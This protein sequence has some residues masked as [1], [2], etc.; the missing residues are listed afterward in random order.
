MW[1]VSSGCCCAKAPQATHDKIMSDTT[2][3]IDVPL[4][5]VHYGACPVSLQSPITPLSARS[6]GV[7]SRAASR[8]SD[9]ATIPLPNSSR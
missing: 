6:C 5:A 1:F 8:D 9:Q 2:L 3:Y 4:V 7:A